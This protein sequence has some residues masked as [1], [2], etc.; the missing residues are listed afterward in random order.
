[1]K[2]IFY[3]IFAM[4][5]LASC[6]YNQ[7]KI[8]ELER[9][10]DS[11]KSVNLEG[12]DKILELLETMDGVQEM[13]DE[14]K[15]KE[16]ILSS[17]KLNGEQK[18][19]L[20]DDI[21]SIKNRLQDYKDKIAN[22]QSSLN[23]QIAAN[24]KL[25]NII[26][27]LEQT[28]KNQESEIN[29]LNSQIADIK[30]YVTK[31]E[32][33]NQKLTQELNNKTSEVATL[34]NKIENIEIENDKAYYIIGTGKDLKTSGIVA[35]KK[36]GKLEKELAVEISKKSIRSISIDSKFKILSSHPDASYQITAQGLE[37]ID[38]KKFWSITDFLVIQKK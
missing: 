25:K 27:N 28:V 6:N 32:E 13:V 30:T 21:E 26:S 22:L 9:Q 7:D 15:Q 37:I 34:N 29:N 11:V 5:F 38:Y 36:I 8:E 18:Q 23:S 3:F 12:N 19:K 35:K 1:M 20:K 24:S 2:K 33:D 16:N 17:N 31:V 10:L 4:T 14:I